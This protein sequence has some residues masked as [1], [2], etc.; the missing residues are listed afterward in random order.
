MLIDQYQDLAGKIANSSSIP[1]SGGASGAGESGANGDCCAKVDSINSDIAELYK[2]VNN[3][4]VEASE[5]TLK[6]IQ[7]DGVRFGNNWWV[8]EQG[9]YLFAIDITQSSYYRFDSGVNKTV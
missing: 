1:P 6:R 2:V 3:L 9:Q 7:S 5:T 8:G 4:T